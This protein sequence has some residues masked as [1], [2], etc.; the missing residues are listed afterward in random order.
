MQKFLFVVEI[1]TKYDRGL[2]FFAAPCRLGWVPK[3]NLVVLLWHVVYR[4]DALPVTQPTQGH[5][6]SGKL[7]NVRE[8]DSCQGNIQAFG[9]SQGNVTE[10]L[11]GEN[12]S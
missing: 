5:Q 11:V 7:G 3:V 4:L 1:F 10:N 12:V 9:K 2:L 6:L 8:F